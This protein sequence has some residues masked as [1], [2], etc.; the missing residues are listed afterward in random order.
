MRGTFD[1]DQELYPHLPQQVGIDE[2]CIRHQLTGEEFD[3][4]PLAGTYGSTERQAQRQALE[5]RALALSRASRTAGGG[6]E[7]AKAVRIDAVVVA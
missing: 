3:R 7:A 1:F 4:Q 6:V 2:V 5:T